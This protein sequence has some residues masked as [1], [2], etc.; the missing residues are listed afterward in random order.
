MKSAHFGRKLASLALAHAGLLLLG[1]GTLG[2]GNRY[3]DYCEA[4]AQCRGGNDADI[5]ACVA[6]VTAA[7]DIAAAY[8]CSDA[9][10]KLADCSE[11]T[12]TCDDQSYSTSCDDE[13]EA[14]GRCIEAA[15]ARDSG[16]GSSVSPGTGGGSGACNALEA[17]CVSCGGTPEACTVPEGSDPDA[18]QAAADLYDELGCD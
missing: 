16:G 1:A 3:A 12:G 10:D 17:K 6:Q 14:L 11:R 7:E 13:N 9:F 18:C 15:S 4:D 8:E 2:C 5:D